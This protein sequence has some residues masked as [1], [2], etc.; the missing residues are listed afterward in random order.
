MHVTHPCC[1]R[2]LG[3]PSTSHNKRNEVADKSKE[4]RQKWRENEYYSAPYVQHNKAESSSQESQEQR[5]AC[6][7][8]IPWFCFKE[9]LVQE[10]DAERASQRITTHQ[11]KQNNHC[12]PNLHPGIIQKGAYHRNGDVTDYCQHDGGNEVKDCSLCAYLHATFLLFS[13]P[14][15]KFLTY[16]IEASR[17]LEYSKGCASGSSGLAL[18]RKWARHPA[19]CSQCAYLSCTVCIPAPRKYMAW[20]CMPATSNSIAISRK[21]AINFSAS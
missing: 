7:D 11:G 20:S 14:T 19:F 2:G 1:L 4:C 12:V 16:S 18:F 21:P 9:Q 13:T 17:A 15:R 3:R 8:G 10:N 6:S 5:H